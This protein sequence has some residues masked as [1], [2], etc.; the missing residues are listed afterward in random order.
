[1]DYADYL[2]ESVEKNISYS[3]YISECIGE[4]INYSEYGYFDYEGIERK[5]IAENRR[6]KIEEILNGTEEK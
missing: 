3:E 1:M 2:S 6:K 4:I 5:R